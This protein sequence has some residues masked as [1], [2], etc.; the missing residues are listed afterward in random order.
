[1]FAIKAVN[2]S[3]R[4]AV[5]A[6]AAAAACWRCSRPTAVACGLTLVPYEDLDQAGR[7]RVI[8]DA[9][10]GSGETLLAVKIACVNAWCV[11]ASS[12]AV[13]AA[14]AKASDSDDDDGADGAEVD[15]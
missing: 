2:G 4:A 11:V 8:L 13:A 6:A 12:A 5:A 14:A 10:A 7:K 3:A 9:F 1:M 15:A